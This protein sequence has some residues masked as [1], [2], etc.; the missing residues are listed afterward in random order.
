MYFFRPLCQF[1]LVFIDLFCGV[2]YPAHETI[3][4]LSYSSKKKIESQSYKI[5]YWLSYWLFFAI[6]R[7]IHSLLYF[8][9]FAYE[10]RVIA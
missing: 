10:I 1:L 6:L 2:I 5:T 8:F 3:F 7:Y 9:P 4:I